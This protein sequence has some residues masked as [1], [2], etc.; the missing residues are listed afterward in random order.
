MPLERFSIGVGD[1]FGRE[2]QAQLRALETARRMGTRITPV[3][4]KSQREHALTGTTPQETRRRADRAVRA[5]GWPD[6]YYVDADHIRML[7]V[8]DYIGPCDFFTIDI[9][10]LIGRPPAAESASVFLKAVS[11][12]VGP[13]RLPGLKT[14]LEITETLIADVT[15][16]YLGAV[17]E[18]G[19]VYR[20]IV[21][22]KDPADI[23]IEVSLDEADA[24]QTPGE[25]L[26]ILAALGRQ[27]VPVRTVAPKFSGAF[28]KGVDYVGDPGEFG[29]ELE[30]DLAILDF[31]RPAFGLPSDLKLSVHSGSDKFSLYPIMHR[32]LGD[33]E[34]GLHLKTAGTTWLEEVAGLAASGGD[35]LRVARE[36]YT[37]AVARFDE[38]ARP[39]RA[40]IDIDRDA[41]PAAREVAAWSGADFVAALEHDPTCPAFNPNLRQL[42]HI[43]FRIA[44]EM[45]DRFT[46]LLDREREP[47]EARVTDNLLRRH[48]GPL[49][50]GGPVRTGAAG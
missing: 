12:L 33:R 2:G 15:L 40:V 30:A 36:L 9:A 8:D 39:Y 25:L 41:L 26:L 49:F 43:A 14:P 35:G 7:T 16:K 3:W 37:A 44:A 1:R 24:P 42:L 18:A 22:K 45:G 28:L 34:A 6:A 23:V 31:A 20:H 21:K 32:A 47:I 29:L 27:G 5:G 11:G 48:V 17:E 50:L 19:R 10:D 4:N 46:D 38:L 13:Q